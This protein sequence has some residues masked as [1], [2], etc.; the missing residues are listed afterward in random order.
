MKKTFLMIAAASL[1]ATACSKSDDDNNQNTNNGST[2]P[3]TAEEVLKAKIGTASAASYSIA[4]DMDISSKTWTAADYSNHAFGETAMNGCDALIN[5]L[6]E[7]TKAVLKSKL[8]PV[9]EEELRTTIAATVCHVIIPTYTQLADAAVKLQQALGDLSATEI[10]QSN[11]DE[12]C[13]AFKTARAWWEMSEAFLGGAASDFDVDPTID[14]WPLN[15]DLLLDY[16][17]DGKYSDEALEDA[18]ILGFHALEFV[19]FRN[20]QNR[21]VTDFQVNDT[22]KGFENVPAAEELKYAQAVAKELVKRCYQL[23]VS[24]ELTPTAN[25]LAV[26]KAAG[27]DYQTKNKLSFSW[28]M[29]N[30]GVSGSGTTFSSLTDALQQ[31]LN[32]S[33]GSCLAI[34]D[35]VGSGKIG[36]PFAEGYIFYVESPYSY[37]SIVDFRN[38]IHSIENIWYGNPQGAKGQAEHSLH[39][40]YTQ[41]APTIAKSVETA[42]AN[43]V[44]GIAGMPYPFVKYVETLSGKKFEDDEIVEIPE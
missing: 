39:N 6:D 18:S 25:R 27:L 12:A 33:E 40:F 24:W 10:K 15:R 41:V 30:A 26:V 42:I 20:G 13:A 2:T 8:T 34:A 28:N 37:N 11:I 43:A 17:K 36:H 23:Q 38:N 14:S 31:L 5:Q 19:L 44:S 29:I 4:N 3:Q 35:E 32:N 21:K 1:L 9:Q 16:F 7:A 22:Y